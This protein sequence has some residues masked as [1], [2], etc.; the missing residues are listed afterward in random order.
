MKKN[1]IGL[2]PGPE[3][4]GLVH[5][6]GKSILHKGIHSNNALLDI[7]D[8]T[9]FGEMNTES[10]LVIEKMQSIYPIY[11][12]KAGNI[13]I[14]TSH[15]MYRQGGKDII[16]TLFWTGRF[17]EFWQGPR[18]LVSREKVKLALCQKTTVGDPEVRKNLILRFGDSI[19]DGLKEHMWAAFAVAVVYFDEMKIKNNIV[20]K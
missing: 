13:I 4:S 5:W 10:I 8:N 15:P 18:E 16:D 12:K 1:V 9:Y 6:D 11:S 2:D 17:Y 19:T 14:N 3:K 20:D 7:L